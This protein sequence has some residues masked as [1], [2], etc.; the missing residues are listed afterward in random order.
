MHDKD[1]MST[2][3]IST[4]YIRS[5]LPDL[6]DMYKLEDDDYGIRVSNQ[7]EQTASRR[8]KFT[9]SRVMHYDY[10]MEGAHFSEITSGILYRLFL[11]YED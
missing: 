3:E 8:A 1:N 4:S 9:W 6:L 11:G 5:S 7:E 2:F 10:E